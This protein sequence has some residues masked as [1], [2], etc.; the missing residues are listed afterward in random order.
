MILLYHLND[1]IKEQRTN[2]ANNFDQYNVIYKLHVHIY[3]SCIPSSR[4]ILTRSRLIGKL[5]HDLL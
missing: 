2:D 5:A 4:T 1:Y 3:I